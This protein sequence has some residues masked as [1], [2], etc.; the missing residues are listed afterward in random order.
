MST[1]Y[2]V[3]PFSCTPFLTDC[4]FSGQEDY[5]FAELFPMAIIGV[6]GGLLGRN[7]H[8]ILY[9]YDEFSAVQFIKLG[10]MICRGLI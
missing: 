10:S 8:I 7:F 4:I 2:Q 6:I 3:F 5:S 1:E 9:F